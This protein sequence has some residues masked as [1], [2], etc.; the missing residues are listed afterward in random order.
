MS[1]RLTVIRNTKK[2][3]MLL[4]EGV[5]LQLFR[6][7][8]SIWNTSRPGMV[9]SIDRYIEMVC[10]GE[11]DR[12]EVTEIITEMGINKISMMAKTTKKGGRADEVWTIVPARGEKINKSRVNKEGRQWDAHEY[13]RIK[14]SDKVEAGQES[15]TMGVKKV[16]E[17]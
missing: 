3:G 17:D 8:R 14:E 6:D 4:L 2:K 7:V 5:E 11:C 13:N 9:G 12:K 1:T 16:V 15:W 10:P